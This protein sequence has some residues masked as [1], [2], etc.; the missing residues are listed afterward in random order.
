[1]CAAAISLSIPIKAYEQP[2][3]LAETTE[4]KGKRRLVTKQLEE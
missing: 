2:L 3:D 1:M 4:K